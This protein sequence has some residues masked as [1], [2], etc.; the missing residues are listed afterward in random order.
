[1]NHLLTLEEVGTQLQR[2]PIMH[3]DCMSLKPWLRMFHLS[4][5]L[6]T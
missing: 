1:M 3:K 6:E 4:L 2:K 5:Q